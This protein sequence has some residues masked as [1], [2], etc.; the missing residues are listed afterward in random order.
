MIAFRMKIFDPKEFNLFAL[1]DGKEHAL[2]D[3]FR[4][5]D[6]TDSS[7]D[8]QGSLTTLPARSTTGTLN[9]IRDRPIPLVS[10]TGRTVPTRS[11]SSRSGSPTSSSNESQGLNKRSAPRGSRHTTHTNP[12]WVLCKKLP[13]ASNENSSGP[14][15]RNGGTGGVPSPETELVGPAPTA[16]D[17]V[18]FP[19][20]GSTRPLLIFRRASGYFAISDRLLQ[21]MAD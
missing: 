15:S 8:L 13:I 20:L 2:D 14:A 1:I 11:V 7:L 4:L 10:Q 12:W 19:L 3:S 9:S 18:S 16:I 17:V 6:F 5:A 21:C